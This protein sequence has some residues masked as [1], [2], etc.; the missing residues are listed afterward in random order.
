M[1]NPPSINISTALELLRGKKTTPQDL[2][3]ACFLQIERLNPTLNA[4]ITVCDP[5]T[6]TNP[7]PSELTIPVALANALRGIPIAVKDLFE[8][9]GIRTTAG[10]KFFADYIPENDAF[11][12]EKLK[13]AG[14]ILM[15]KTNT[16]EIAL[17]V[18]GNNPHYGT[19]RNPWNTE[20][21]P[22]GSSSG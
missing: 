9:A 19:A 20:R 13:Q 11:V 10:S 18:T 14:A 12:I 6:P 3:E 16:H 8:T 5:Q 2:A 15:G 17:G 22:G 4:F 7:Q 1:D 21:I